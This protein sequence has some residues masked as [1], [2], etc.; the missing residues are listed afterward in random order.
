LE[1]LFT[2]SILL[3]ILVFS[4]LSRFSPIHSP[5]TR[6]AHSL[7]RSFLTVSSGFLEFSTRC[8]W[9]SS[10]TLFSTD[11][12]NFSL[13]LSL[14]DSLSCLLSLPALSFHRLSHLSFLCLCLSYSRSNFRFYRFSTFTILG[15]TSFFTFLPGIFLHLSSFS[16]SARFLGSGVTARSFWRSLFV[17]RFSGIFLCTHFLYRFC[18]ISGT[19]RF[20]HVLHGFLGSH[21]PGISCL[22]RTFSP[23]YHV[24]W[25]CTLPWRVSFFL[26]LPLGGRICTA[27]SPAVPTLESHSLFFCSFSVPLGGDA[28]HLS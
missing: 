13:F 11:F 18:G 8:S 17:S 26:H 4:V 15:T 19:L 2:Y 27:T 10:L 7:W 22:F 23:A 1:F 14:C 16:L 6:S 5:L 9:V 20:S 24:L 3:Q 25:V 21:V 28:S 12:W